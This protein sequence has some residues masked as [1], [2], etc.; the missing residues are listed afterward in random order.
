MYLLPS[1]TKLLTGGDLIQIWC[2]SQETPDSDTG[3]K[4]VK[5]SL[6]HH[7]DLGRHGSNMYDE[8]QSFVKPEHDIEIIW[9][10][11]WRCRFVYHSS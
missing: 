1:G 6:G 2:I 4:S 9:E 11:V 3:R 8:E 5:F 7:D 10:A